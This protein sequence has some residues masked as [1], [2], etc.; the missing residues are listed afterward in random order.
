MAVANSKESCARI[1]GKKVFD[2]IVDDYAGSKGK[3]E[4]TPEENKLLDQ[5]T[6]FV[7]DNVVNAKIAKAYAQCMKCKTFYPE[8][9]PPINSPL[10]RGLNVRFN[11][12]PKLG[13]DFTK[14]KYE[15]SIA[16]Q[17][18]VGYP[19]TYKPRRDVESFT[20]NIKVAEEFAGIGPYANSDA[21]AEYKDFNRYYS[22]IDTLVKKYI[23]ITKQMVAAK[24]GNNYDKYMALE[25]KSFDIGGKITDVVDDANE[26]WKTSY[27]MISVMLQI[28]ADPTCIFKPDLSNRIALGVGLDREYEVARIGGSTKCIM[29]IPRGFADFAIATHNLQKVIKKSGIKGIEKVTVPKTL[30]LQKAT[31]LQSS[32]K[33]LKALKGK[34]P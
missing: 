6:D 27:T 21:Y 3:E 28:T 9:Q 4:N 2:V 8:L 24:K 1:F 30:G 5:V 15:R 34:L 31:A 17:K 13:I 18:F 32:L 33:N 11:D 16:N 22:K 19:S 25:D 12:A 10:Y 26:F 14:V 7:G 29:W 20:T 23:D